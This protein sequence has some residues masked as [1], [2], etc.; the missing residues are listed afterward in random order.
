MLSCLGVFG[1]AGSLHVYRT[2]FSN[3]YTNTRDDL[4]ETSVVLFLGPMF[5]YTASIWY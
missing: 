3:V 5:F 2:V 4:E 1:C